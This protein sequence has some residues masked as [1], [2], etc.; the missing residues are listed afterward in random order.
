ML[1]DICRK[2]ARICC[3]RRLFAELT[4]DLVSSK[5]L[6][7]YQMPSRTRAKT[8]GLAFIQRMLVCPKGGKCYCGITALPIFGA[9]KT[10]N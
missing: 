4:L 5:S 9:R 8:F 2:A 10:K 7:L 1:F 6:D 3:M